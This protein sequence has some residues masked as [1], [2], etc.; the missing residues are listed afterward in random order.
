MTRSLRKIHFYW[1]RIVALLL[2]VLFFLSIWWRPANHIEKAQSELHSK[3]L[4]P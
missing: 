4:Q 1:W 3:T 2:P